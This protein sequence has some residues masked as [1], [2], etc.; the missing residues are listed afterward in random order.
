MEFVV[1]GRIAGNGIDYLQLIWRRCKQQV[2]ML[3][4][5]VDEKQPRRLQ[6]CQIYRGIVDERTGAACGADFAA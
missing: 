2:L 1:E 4:M 5:Y 6:L 3:R